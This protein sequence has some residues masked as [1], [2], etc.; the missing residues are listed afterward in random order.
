MDALILKIATRTTIE[1]GVMPWAYKRTRLR[2]LV[3]IARSVGNPVS[4]GVGFVSPEN[5]RAASVNHHSG[6]R[7]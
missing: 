7:L 2:L 4:E 3:R 1:T 5:T 6:S